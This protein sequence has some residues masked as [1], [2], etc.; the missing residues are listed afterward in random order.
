MIPQTQSGAYGQNI[1][2]VFKTGLRCHSCPKSCVKISSDCDK[3]LLRKLSRK[4]VCE[5]V[6]SQIDG[7]GINS[8][9]IYFRAEV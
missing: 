1:N 4:Q 5:Q 2:Q 6:H 3:K 7:R 9:T 8:I